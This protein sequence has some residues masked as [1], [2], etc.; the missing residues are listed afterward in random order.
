MKRMLSILILLSVTGKSNA[1]DDLQ[2]S[3][4]R[5]AADVAREYVKPAVSGFGANMNSGWFHKPPSAKKFGFNFEFGM[6]GML[7][8]S[9]NSNRHFS[10]GSLLLFDSTDA[11]RITDGIDTLAR[12]TGYDT[13]QLRIISGELK[14]Q[15]SGYNVKVKISGGTFSG[16]K[17]D[18]IRIQYD[19]GPLYFT[20]P[21]TGQTDSIDLRSA[22]KAIIMKSAGLG[23]Q[24]LPFYCYQFSVG[25]IYGTQFTLRF[26]PAGKPKKES[27]RFSYGGLGI[28][29]NPKVWSDKKWP[30]DVAIGLFTQKM[31]QGNFFEA[32]AS[33]FGVTVGK[34][35]G[36]RFLNI[37][38]YA[39]L[40]AESSYMKF[41][42]EYENSA[43]ETEKVT[44]NLK[45]KNRSRLTLGSSFRAAI[46]NFN[47]DYSFGKYDVVSTGLTLAF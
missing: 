1:Q 20:N 19:G 40:M 32:G 41:K 37:S 42:Y 45:G 5:L 3:V 8:F 31:K 17:K 25:T 46:V 33:A 26:L 27:G 16:N 34:Q 44:I 2:S 14:S 21:Q 36:W 4:V 23:M 47:I 10:V 7:S 43:G 11:V 29:H 13:N 24:A 15:L 12:F 9:P 18:S 28:Q 39:G 22:G 38:P 30:V 35:F 6:V